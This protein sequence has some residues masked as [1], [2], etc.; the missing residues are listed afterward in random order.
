MLKNKIHS[1]QLWP[2]KVRWPE[3]VS[4]PFQ[5]RGNL[6]PRFLF[7]QNKCGKLKF[8]HINFGQKKSTVA[9]C[10]LRALPKAGEFIPPPPPLSEGHGDGYQIK[11]IFLI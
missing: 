8:N 1:H 5:K 9:G 2:K 7:A 3:P 6:F 4:V 10:C 11:M